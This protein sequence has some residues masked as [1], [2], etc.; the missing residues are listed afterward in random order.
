MEGT[1]TEYAQVSERG[2]VARLRDIFNRVHILD[3]EMFQRHIEPVAH[4]FQPFK[5]K[6]RSGTNTRGKLWKCPIMCFSHKAHDHAGRGTHQI[7]HGHITCGRLALCELWRSCR[8]LE[9]MWR[10]HKSHL[11]I[12]MVTNVKYYN[13]IGE[14]TW[15]VLTMRNRWHRSDQIVSPKAPSL[16]NERQFWLLQKDVILYTHIFH[17]K[18]NYQHE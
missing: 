2:G 13:V 3:E 4:K 5:R 14:S 11:S 18:F 6:L 15:S 8:K 7:K 17:A 10:N 1:V 12:T 16:Y 9:K